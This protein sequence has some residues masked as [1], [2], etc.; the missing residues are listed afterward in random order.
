[1][2]KILKRIL[3]VATTLFFAQTSSAQ[4]SQ[5]Y[6]AIAFDYVRNNIESSSSIPWRFES[7]SYDKMPNGDYIVKLTIK[8]TRTI[9]DGNG[10]YDP[11]VRGFIYRDEIIEE[12]ES[13]FVFVDRFGEP[14]KYMTSST[15]HE[16]H[17]WEGNAWLIMN[18]HEEGTG[19]RHFEYH[20]NIACFS[21]NGDVR[22]NARDMK[23]YGWNVTNSTLYLAG[24][25]H[26]N[27]RSVVRTVNL[28]TF[29]STD[30]VGNQGETPYQVSFESEGVKIM[31][32]KTDGQL[33]DFTMPYSANDRQFQIN[34]L[35]QTYNLNNAS[36]QVAL[37]ERYLN[38]SVVDKDEKKAVELFEKA[39]NQNNPLGLLRLA[40]CYNEGIGVVQDVPKALSLFEKSAN[41]GNTEAAQALSDIYADGKGVEKNASKALY[42]KE[43]LAFA[44]DW[45]AQKYVLAYQSMEYEKYN[46]SAEEVYRIAIDN[47]KEKNYEWAKFCFERAI[48][49]GSKDAM[50]KY[51]EWLYLGNGIT[52]DCDKAIEY[53]SKLGEEDN[54]LEAQIMLIGIYHE[55]K[56]VSPDIKK[57]I[58]W[59]IK[60][61]DNGNV[62]AQ[63]ALGDAFQNGI[64]VKKNKKSAFAMYEKAAEQGNQVAIKKMVYWF[65]TGNGVKKNIYGSMM[66]FKK[67]DLEAQL[68]IA[69]DFENGAGGKK[70]IEIAMTMY[71]NIAKNNNTSTSWASFS[72]LPTASIQ[73]KLRRGKA[74]YKLVELYIKSGRLDEAQTVLA[75]IIGEADDYSLGSYYQGMIWEKKGRIQQALTCYKNSSLPAAK[76]R[77]DLLH[78]VWRRNNYR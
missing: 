25:Y 26:N 5:N 55:N 66:W 54:N 58:Y 23:I 75:N 7:A 51:G 31:V 9:R 53:L 32:F 67:L 70:S 37:G 35:M 2:K 1:M 15:D 59:L 30:K 50:L 39:A 45:D 21:N 28:R 6:Q 11:R 65:A 19:N 20:N 61:A 69:Q 13:Y 17:Y 68:M 38:G 52:K 14:H 47:H 77:Y 12:R 40:T 57:E 16:F 78:S 29:E 41:M 71:E 74:A 62:Y 36:D 43:K 76:Q 63:M 49:L 4:E 48:S 73:E 22:W 34:K 33:S 60:A 44:G 72:T 10:T 64:G 56:G 3:F 27:G 18:K 24:K 8:R 42:W 46:I